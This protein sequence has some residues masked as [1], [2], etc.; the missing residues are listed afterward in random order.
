MTLSVTKIKKRIALILAVF[1]LLAVSACGKAVH[2][3][4]A[5]PRR[6]RTHDS[7]GKLTGSTEVEYDEHGNPVR[8]TS[9]DKS[10]INQASLSLYGPD[11]Q[12]IEESRKTKTDTVFRVTVF[13]NAYDEKGQLIRVDTSTNGEPD[14]SS[15]YEYN[16]SGQI[17]RTE[18]RGKNSLTVKTD[19]Y[20]AEGLKSRSVIHFSRWD[21]TTAEPFAQTTETL[22]TYDARGLLIKSESDR[23]VTSY[24]YE[25]NA[26]GQ[27]TRK[28]AELDGAV[29]AETYEYNKSG[30]LVRTNYY[31]NAGTANE[32]M[33]FYVVL[34]Y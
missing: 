17:I 12:L 30:Q 11:G 7:L 31:A 28:E 6:I 29:E 14:T 9:S 27:M 33:E 32:S 10:K 1:L 25:H 20:N 19:E 3:A 13:D 21:D 2:S 5:K 15:I 24:T 4:E 26:R 18:Q 16:E 22:Y 23:G 34:K 8:Q